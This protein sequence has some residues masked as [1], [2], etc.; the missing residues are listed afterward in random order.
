MPSIRSYFLKKIFVQKLNKIFPYSST[1]RQNDSVLD[2]EFNY[3]HLNHIKKILSFL[4][5][6]RK[7]NLLGKKKYFLSV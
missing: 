2:V 3:D 5:H 6:S 7:I 1:I 4:L